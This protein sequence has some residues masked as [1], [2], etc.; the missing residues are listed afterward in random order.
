MVDFVGGIGD[1]AW[2]GTELGDMA[3]GNGGNGFGNTLFLSMI[4]DERSIRRDSLWI[5]IR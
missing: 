3:T 4:A 2:V 5:G 1:D